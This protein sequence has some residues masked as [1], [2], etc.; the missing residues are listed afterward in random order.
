MAECAELGQQPQRVR[1]RV[2]GG[3]V[4]RHHQQ[5]EERRQFRAGELLAVHVGVHQRR[6]EIVRWVA[7]PGGGQV[8]DQRAQFLGGGGYLP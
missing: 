2:A 6:H 4:A 1:D 5:D 7:L 8:G 3:L